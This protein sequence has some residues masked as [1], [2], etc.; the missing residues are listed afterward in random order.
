VEA[1]VLL[2]RPANEPD[3]DVRIA[4]ELEVVPL[5][6]IVVRERLP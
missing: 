3:V 2:V 6:G 1:G 5:S 4:V